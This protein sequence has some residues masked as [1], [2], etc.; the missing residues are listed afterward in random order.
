[1]TLSKFVVAGLLA[2]SLALPTGAAHATAI[3]GYLAGDNAFFAYISTDDSVRGTLL[4]A[5]GMVPGQPRENYFQ[6]FSLSSALTAG[7]TNYLHIEV[8]NSGGPNMLIG[9]FSL[10]DSGFNFANGSQTLV[11]DTVNWTGAVNNANSDIN[12]QQP[13]T[14][15]PTLSPTSFGPFGVYPWGNA[16]SASFQA[17]IVGSGAQFIGFYTGESVSCDNGCTMNFSTAITPNGVPAPGALPLLW[18]GL[19]GLGVARRRKF[20]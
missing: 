14:A 15:A 20:I 5:Q 6:G 12:A 8:I 18:L 13:W 17:Q 3:T 7:V 2:L 16:F 19:A 1:M 11:T 9:A 10:S 4:S